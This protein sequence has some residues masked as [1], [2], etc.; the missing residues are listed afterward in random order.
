MVNRGIEAE[1]LSFCADNAIGVVVYSPMQA[2]LLTG[3]FTVER[4]ATLPGD[5]WRHKSDHFH[6]PALSATLELVERLRTIAERAGRSLSQLAIAWTLRRTEV[7]SAI[8]GARRPDQISETAAAGDWV[9]TE[10]EVEEI[11]ALLLERD[12]AI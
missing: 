2:G 7:T 12:R 6:E 8:V 11:S 4:M 5:D 9:L 3:T 1:L 10:A